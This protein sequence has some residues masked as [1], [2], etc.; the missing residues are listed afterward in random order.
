MTQHSLLAPLCY[1]CKL[2]KLGA[3]RV[4][5]RESCVIFLFTLDWSLVTNH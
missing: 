5:V 2:V 3:S 1:L 4:A